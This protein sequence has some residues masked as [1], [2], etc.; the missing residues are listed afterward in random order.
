MSKRKPKI[1]LGL[2]E[3]AGYYSSLSRGF[4]GLGYQST[5]VVRIDDKFGFEKGDKNLLINTWKALVAKRRTTPKSKIPSKIIWVVLHQ[6]VTIILFIWALVRFDVFIFSFAS[7]FFNYKELPIL[8]FFGKKVI[9]VF[10]GTDSRPP[11]LNGKYLSNSTDQVISETI[12]MKKR[13]KS[14]EKYADY[15]I[16]NPPQG[17]LYE[18]PFINRMYIGS[19]VSFNFDK[20]D[21]PYTDEAEKKT[22][23]VVVAHLPSDPKTKGTNDIRDA[24]SGLKEQGCNID[25]V[26]V[27]DVSQKEV[28]ATIAKSDFVIDQIYSDYFITGIMREAAYLGKP[29]I[30]GG[31][32]V[33]YYKDDYSDDLPVCLCRPEDIKQAILEMVKNEKNR[34]QLG[35][36]AE[37]YIKEYN[38]PTEVAKRYLRLIGND[39][40]DKWYFDPKSITY[41]YGYGM[42]K[43]EIKKVIGDI[44]EKAGISALQIADKPELEK[45]F[46]QISGSSRFKRG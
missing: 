21:L 2:N 30:I 26:E 14:I 32:Y 12:A 7:T 9:H 45:I 42:R 20:A 31:Y 28:L 19:P 44:I 40:P 8:K 16:C 10:H 34:K 15:I 43:N 39:A 35:K 29:T 24:I 41:V 36:R 38:S 27:T 3:I 18:K 6:I 33:D 4:K 25:Y 5:L 17:H 46:S 37:K 22:S 11:Y 23:S 1:F 13:L